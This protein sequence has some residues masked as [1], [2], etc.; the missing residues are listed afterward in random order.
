M[1]LFRCLAL[2]LSLAAPAAFAGGPYQVELVVFRQAGDAVPSSQPAPDDWATGAQPL[3]SDALRATA[4]DNQLAKLSQDNGY[5]VLLHKAWRQDIGE[6]PVKIALSE[7]QEQDHH[8]PVEGT[9]T[10]SQVRFVDMEADFW[11]NRFGD[12][13][14][15]AGSQ[16]IRQGTRLKNGELTYLDHPSLGILIKVV[17]VGARPAAPNPMEMEEQQ[18]PAD[19]PPSKA[20]STPHLLR[21][22]EKGRNSGLFFVAMAA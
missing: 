7:G 14:F 17:P 15:L 1:R 19:A 11:V 6:T 8:F 21:N 16:H 13:G 9:L 20:A 3:A 5:T 18:A 10:L 2:L 12:D 22:S 4:L